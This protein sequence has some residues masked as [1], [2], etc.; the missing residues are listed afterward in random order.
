MIYPK[1]HRIKITQDDD[2]LTIR[3]QWTNR[4]LAV[5]APF[6]FILPLSPLISLIMGTSSGE[7][8]NLI[9]LFGITSVSAIFFWPL[10]YCALALGA[11]ST[12]ITATKERLNVKSGPNF[13]HR[14][15][16]YDAIDIIQFF[17]NGVGF[18]HDHGDSVKLLDAMHIVRPV[19]DNL[20]GH[21]AALDIKRTLQA[22]FGLEDKE[23]YGV[24]THRNPDHT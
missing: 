12:T 21:I 3:Y 1:D 4:V 7:P 2:T 13:W 23:I 11:N 5:I 8:Q 10:S 16:E 15:R 17:E 14:V 22:F 24:T 20:P 19:A 6:L 9:P 18:S